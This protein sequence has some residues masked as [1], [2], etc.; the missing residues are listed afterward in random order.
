MCKTMWKKPCRRAG[1]RRSKGAPTADGRGKKG[2]FPPE[3]TA[4][5]EE[6][7][8]FFKNM[9]DKNYMRMV[10]L[11]A[12]MQKRMTIPLSSTADTV[13]QVCRRIKMFE[14]YFKQQGRAYHIC[15]IL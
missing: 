7:D 13:P 10:Q 8:A 1:R 11:I 4:Q 15:A 12:Y 2:G 14:L 9:L 5:N 6:Y 3:E